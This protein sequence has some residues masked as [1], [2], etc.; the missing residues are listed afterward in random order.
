[1]TLPPLPDPYLHQSALDVMNAGWKGPVYT[2]D[3][4]LAYATEATA[5]PLT[6]A[7]RH[8]D[9]LVEALNWCVVEINR[10]SPSVVN[11]AKVMAKIEGG[12]T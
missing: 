4:M 1:M 10:Q 3:Q 9:E 6:P 7:A 2:A 8:A 5:Q 12:A 11:A